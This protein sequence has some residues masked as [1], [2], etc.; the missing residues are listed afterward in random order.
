M[1]P[2]SPADRSIRV[3]D[4]A[5]KFSDGLLDRDQLDRVGDRKRGLR[6]RDELL[7]R[8]DECDLVILFLRVS[9]FS[10]LLQSAVSICS[11]RAITA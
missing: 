10:T 9:H 4:L 2:N 3:A 7:V 8:R 6:R 11:S 5:L 1:L